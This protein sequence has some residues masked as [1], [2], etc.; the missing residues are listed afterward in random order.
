MKDKVKELRVRLHLFMLFVMSHRA[1]RLEQSPD[2]AMAKLSLTSAR[3]WMGK[4]LGQLGEENPY[5]NSTQ[6]NGII[7]PPADTS[8]REPWPV[9]DPIEQ[10]KWLRGKIETELAKVK[11]IRDELI[12]QLVGNT[13]T[14]RGPVPATAIDLRMVSINQVLIHLTEAKM[15]LGEEL[16]A[17]FDGGHLEPVA[18]TT[19]APIAEAPLRS[20]G[21]STGAHHDTN[22]SMG[23]DNE[24]ADRGNT[25]VNGKQ[26][27]PASQFRELGPYELQKG[28]ENSGEGDARWETNAGPSK[29]RQQATGYVATEGIM[30]GPMPD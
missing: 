26:P 12:V 23:I 8:G 3:H 28:P 30:G 25:P 5:P 29:D 24:V 11:G 1:W 7:E 18:D 13:I 27:A 10:I 20:A 16:G 6:M 21:G 4:L 22:G 9:S 19:Q 2:M 14:L 15:W 17:K